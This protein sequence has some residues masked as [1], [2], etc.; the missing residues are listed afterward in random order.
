MNKW[1]DSDQK[2]LDLFGV[3]NLTYLTHILTKEN[4]KKW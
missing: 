3:I 1:S 2:D 4:I